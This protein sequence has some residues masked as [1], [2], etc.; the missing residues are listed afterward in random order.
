MHPG[1]RSLALG[2]IER[3]K[4]TPVIISASGGL[5]R[6]PLSSSAQGGWGVEGDVELTLNVRML[7]LCTR[8]AL[9]AHKP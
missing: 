9:R 3:R 2:F 6:D 4:T 5:R 7:M 1:L 8:L